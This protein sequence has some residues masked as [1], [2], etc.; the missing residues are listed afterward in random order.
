M[1]NCATHHVAVLMWMADESGL[2]LKA[3]GLLM[4]LNVKLRIGV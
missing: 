2:L 1:T 4:F 3:E